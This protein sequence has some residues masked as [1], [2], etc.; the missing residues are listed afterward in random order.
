MHA[1]G[2][3]RNS[4]IDEM[5]DDDGQALVSIVHRAAF[6]RELLRDAPPERLHASKRLAR[7]ERAD[8]DGPVTLHFTDETR[9]ECDI[10]VGAGGIRSTVRRGILGERDPATNV[11]NAGWW[12]VMALKSYADVRASI[13]EGL[14]DIDDTREHGW[15]GDGAFLM[16]DILNE[17]QLVQ[18]IISV[19]EKEAEGSDKWYRMVSAEEISKVYWDWP[20]HLK[21]AAEEPEQRAIYNWEHPHARTYVSGPICIMGDAAHAMTPF[22]GSGCGMSFEDALILY[23]LLGGSKTPAEALVDLQVYD[24]VRRPRTQ[25]I[26]ESSRNTGRIITGEGEEI[27]LDLENPRQ[28]QLPRWDFIID[29]DNVNARDESVEMMI[30]ELAK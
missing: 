20:L 23:T 17:G 27:G 16:H 2:E 7:V 28:G 18:F 21:N 11:R 26:V 19:R 12:A 25:R 29:F 24:Q 13:G 8:E 6:L 30:A 4:M 15:V 22:Q 14:V 10:V 1:Q 3:G 9:H 5:R